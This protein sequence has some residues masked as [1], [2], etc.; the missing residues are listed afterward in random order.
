MCFGFVGVIILM[1]VSQFST[2][3][4]FVWC[5]LANS[6]YRYSANS[7]KDCLVWL[8]GRQVDL[9]A[10]PACYFG[11][12]RAIYSLS[13]TNADLPVISWKKWVSSR[14]MKAASCR[15][16]DFDSAD[17]VVPKACC[18]SILGSDP[19]VH[20]SLTVPA[21]SGT[22]YCW[23]VVASSEHSCSCESWRYF[24]CTAAATLWCPYCP[25]RVSMVSAQFVVAQTAFGNLLWY[26]RRAI[27]T[28]G[29]SLACPL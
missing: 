19:F 2:D 18:S 12:M 15:L 6:C 29:K 26:C 20:P 3:W 25:I 13:N 28:R 5:W 8:F 9:L 21:S 24:W 7:Q 27:C 4:H 22:R 1:K 14:W 17:S 16:K 23:S 10:A 11:C